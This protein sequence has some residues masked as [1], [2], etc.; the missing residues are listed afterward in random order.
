MQI[1]LAENIKKLRLEHSLTQE[2]LAEALGVTVGA[3][4][5]WESGQSMP[6]I[7]LLV[8]IAEF[9]ETSVDALLGYGWEH[10]NIKRICDKLYALMRERKFDEAN[11]LSEKAILRY[12]NNFEIVYSAAE[13]YYLASPRKQA[14]IL[15]AIGLYRDCLRLIDQNTHSNVSAESIEI[16]VALCHYELGHADEALKILKKHNSQ[17]RNEYLIGFI[18]SELGGRTNEALEHL[19]EAFGLCYTRLFSI[20]LAYTNVYTEN[21]DF[22]RLKALLKLVY[23]FTQGLRDATNVT[24]LDRGD[25]RIFTILAAVA[26]DENDSDAAKSYLRRAKLLAERFDA[27]PDYSLTQLYFYHGWEGQSAFDDM[28]QTAIEIIENHIAENELAK[29]LLPI[30]EEIKN[31]K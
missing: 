7:R 9:F 8:E 23:N 11:R 6:E 18:L 24:Y 28:G 12:P 16:T 25:V 13:A 15:R 29:K 4:Y 10:G 27:S 5:K 17:G 31:E 20:A 3:V 21:R 19:S 2:R 30:W 1:K 22:D 26:L 14:R